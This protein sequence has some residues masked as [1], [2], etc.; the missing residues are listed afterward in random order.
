M[1][2]Q[3]IKL[4]GFIGIQKGL[5]LE[6]VSLDL[7]GLSGLVAFAGANGKGKSTI[8][9]NL[10]G[11]P[12][13]ASRKGALQHHVFLRDSYRDLTFTF[14]GDEIR[15]LIKID[16][17]SQKSEGYV[18]VN[19]QPKIDGKISNYKAFMK[20]LLGSP[21]LFFNSVFSSQNG[22]KISDMTTGE[23]KALFSEFLRLHLLEQYEQTSKQA[24]IILGGRQADIDR[25]IE[26]LVLAVAEKDETRKNHANL[27]DRKGDVHQTTEKLKAHLKAAEEQLS[28]LQ[29]KAGKNLLLKERLKDYEK[30]K[31]VIEKEIAESESLSL[32]ELNEARQAAKKVAD[33]IVSCEVLLADKDKIRKSV[34]KVAELKTESEALTIRAESCQVAITQI[35]TRIND[36][37]KGHANLLA[38]KTSFEGDTEMATLKAELKALKAQTEALSKRAEDPGCPAK[39]AVCLFV[40]SAVE[41]KAKIPVKEKEIEGKELYKRGL[42]EDVMSQIKALEEQIKPEKID[43]G[44]KTEE[45]KAIKGGLSVIKEAL[46]PLEKLAAKAPDIQV[47]ESK[48]ADL[49]EKKKD[50]IE[51]GLYLKSSWDQKITTQQQNFE[52][53]KT[54]IEDTTKSI[55]ASIDVSIKDTRETITTLKTDIEK[56]ETQAQEVAGRIMAI[57]QRLKEIEG[58]EKELKTAREKRGQVVTE[59]SDWSYIKTACGKDGLRALEIDS[60]APVISAYA[61]DLL[62]RTFG[63]QFSVRFRTQ[64]EDGREVLDILVIR[65]DGGE[66]LLENLSGGES[67]WILKSLRLAMMLISREKSGKSYSSFFCDEEDGPL[68]SE[69][70]VHFIN[71]YRSCLE[72]AGMETCFYISHRPEAIEMADYLVSFNGKGIEIN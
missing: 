67:V 24:A 64:D 18:W 45:Q 47:A 51:K 41:A 66:V 11:Y 59:I 8:L 1:K 46:A 57:E 17:D 40:K 35:S 68:S 19:G 16:S 12:Q 25:Q 39:D 54:L 4:R 33:Q 42:I 31:G 5:G 28:A 22:K 34:E 36:L 13:L 14:D 44:V 72:V 58:K 27:T 69:N 26:T 20:E 61:N 29:E 55:D 6:D 65:D 3:S 37:E 21:E 56:N 62:G 38:R 2:I 7:S 9:E 60:T 48:L 49:E 43:L 15:T 52:G 30:Q 32:K 10:H 71:L 63:Q 23:L 53:I 70:A 50:L